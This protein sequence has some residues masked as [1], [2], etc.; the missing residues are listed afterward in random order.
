M[1]EK[2][3]VNDVAE[4]LADPDGAVVEAVDDFLELPHPASSPTPSARDKP[5][6]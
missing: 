4:M 5:P 2:S 1:A 3:L 6:I